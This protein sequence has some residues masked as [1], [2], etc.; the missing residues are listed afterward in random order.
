[1]LR[2]DTHH[3]GRKVILVGNNNI[4]EMNCILGKYFFNDKQKLKAEDLN[5]FIALNDP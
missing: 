3:S 2:S 5:A 1:M 4:L